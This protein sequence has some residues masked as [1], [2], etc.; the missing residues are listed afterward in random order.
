MPM[1]PDDSPAQETGPR[2]NEPPGPQPGSPGPTVPLPPTGPANTPV[3]PTQPAVGSPPGPQYYAPGPPQPT[4]PPQ[5]P[6]PTYPPYPPGPPF[7]VAQPPV[8]GPPGQPPYPP[9]P[10]QPGQ[11]QYPMA[12]QPQVRKRKIWPWVV[13]IVG[14][15]FVIGIIGI[16][17]LAI[18]GFALFKTV[19]A[20]ADSVN[21][22]F[23]ALHDK[24][25]GQAYNRLCAS[26]K[27]TQ[28]GDE[29]QKGLEA[30]L[31]EAGGI[32][33]WNVDSLS[34]QNSNGTVKGE[35]NL[36]G[37]TQP[38]TFAVVKEGGKWKLCNVLQ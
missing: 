15:L 6:G 31:S 1:P 33:T 12:G 26:D 2:T 36:G 18:T 25:Y 10:Q 23:Q 29:F 22:Y 38:F 30:S 20:P 24:N 7:P 14:G 19:S 8:S 21:S 37:K 17:A 28:T 34:T 5:P 11:P 3:P 16:T 13:G 4:A 35:L 9:R 27:T 32:K